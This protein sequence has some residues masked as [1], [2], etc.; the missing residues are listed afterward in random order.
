MLTA[1][2]LEGFKSIGQR[3]RIELAPLTLLVG[4]DGVGKGIVFDA[5]VYL[6]EL[7]E[8]GRAD[9]DRTMV[10]GERVELGGFSRLV[11]GR[12]PT[13]AIVL[14][15]EFTTPGGLDRLGSATDDFPFPDLEDELDSAWVELTVR[16]RGTS[17]SSEPIV[18]RVAIGVASTAEPV[19]W[20]EAGPSLQDGEPLHVH[21]D[22]QHPLLAEASPRVARAWRSLAIA[23]PEH[24]G[25]LVFASSRSRR[26]ALPPLR[27]P[28]R[29]IPPAPCTSAPSMLAA[30]QAFLEMVVQGIPNQLV[31]ALRPMLY[32]SSF[33]TIP[34]QEFLYE[35]EGRSSSWAHG[36]AAWDHLL[37]DRSLVA[38][39]NQW[40]SRLGTGCRVITQSLVD[41]TARSLVG[42][43]PATQ[44]LRLHGPMGAPM[45]PAEAGA[46]ISQLLPVIVASLANEGGLSLFEQPENHVHPAIQVGLG[47][48]FIEAASRG[49]GRRTLLVETHS[50]HLILRVLR[51]IR[52]TTEGESTDALPS[53]SPERLSVLQVTHDP[54]GVAFRRLRVSGGGDFLDRWPG[55]FFDERASEA[56]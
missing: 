34:P 25:Q 14:R 53:F 51:R 16:M 45:L 28:L 24:P 13:R 52:Q 9:V 56:W 21:V 7:L 8:H 29:V 44:R 22:L 11:H 26:S 36:L 20:L 48:L 38:P 12:D 19:V 31:D 46:G 54:S 41:P 4:C 2:H 47:D 5:L 17:T 43:L 39:T 42:P 37:A 55:G 35:H 49:G 40:L 30:L 23:G 6:L 1:L 50:E 32:V 15:A 18:D 3:Q 27:E 10:A 33:R